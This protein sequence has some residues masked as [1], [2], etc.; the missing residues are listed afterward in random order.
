MDINELIEDLYNLDKVLGDRKSRDKST[1][2]L[3]TFL[4][5]Q[6]KESKLLELYKELSNIYRDT[7]IRGRIITVEET[8]ILEKNKKIRRG[9]GINMAYNLKISKKRKW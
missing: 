4:K 7:A 2:R 1:T 6:E 3:L 8:T 5:K 9:I